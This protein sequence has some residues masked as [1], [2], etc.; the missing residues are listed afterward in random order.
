MYNAQCAMPNSQLF[1]I[2]LPRTN[3]QIPS[4]SSNNPPGIASM[5]P[6]G[7]PR[8]SATDPANNNTY[9]I[10]PQTAIHTGIIRARH[11]KRQKTAPPRPSAIIAIW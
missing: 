5:T 4:A 10:R 2:Y 8:S 11:N 6:I 1:K 9:P 7:Y 3:H